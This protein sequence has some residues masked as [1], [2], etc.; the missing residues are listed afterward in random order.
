MVI[1]GSL[2]GLSRVLRDRIKI[3]VQCMGFLLLSGPGCARQ[4]SVDWQ[5]VQRCTRSKWLQR[6]MV[7]AGVETRRRGI[8]AAPTFF[9]DGVKN[10]MMQSNA[11]AVVCGSYRG[12]R[13]PGA[14]R[15]YRGGY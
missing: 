14:C 5:K 8:E 11:V 2:W 3:G 1:V 4:F 10:G 6:R 7:E 9:V 13:L 15:Q 12:S